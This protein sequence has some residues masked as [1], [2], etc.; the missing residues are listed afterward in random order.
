MV[1]IGLSLTLVEQ[2]GKSEGWGKEGYRV[3]ER[4]MMPGSVKDYIF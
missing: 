3:S 1:H 2:K 4:L